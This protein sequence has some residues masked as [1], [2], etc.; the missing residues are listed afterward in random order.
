MESIIIYGTQYGT[1]KDY[2]EKLSE[3]TGIPIINY[4]EAGELSK[5]TTII[6]MG[7]L[8][9]GGVK[10][11]KTTLKVLPV[12][13]NFIIVTV[14][15]ADVTN[16]ENT[17]HIRLSVSRQVPK[18]VFEKTRIFHLRGGMDYKKLSLAHRSMM[19]LVYNK[20][21]NLPEDEKTAEVRDMIAT[22]GQ[23]VNFIDYSC[24]KPI[25]E[26]VNLIKNNG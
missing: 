8:Y 2:A 24:L 20:A 7:G 5:Y 26:I 1:T 13:A 6:H 3:M 9:A 12:N 22:Y 19:R 10:G 23:T 14:G 11:L 25:A 16:P 15:L 17:A 4:K 18:E 21:K